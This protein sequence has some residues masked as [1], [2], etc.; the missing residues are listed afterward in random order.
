MMG[1]ERR[2]MII[3]EKDKRITAWHEAGHA[4]WRS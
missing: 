2:S 4:W 3:S 1:A